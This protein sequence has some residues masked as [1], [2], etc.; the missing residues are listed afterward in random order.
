MSKIICADCEERPIQKDM[1]LC[2]KCAPNGW[3][4]YWFCPHCGDELMTQTKQHLVNSNSVCESCNGSFHL[5]SKYRA[6]KLEVRD[7]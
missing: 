3:S 2:D 7:E 1:M 6:T 5:E 4:N